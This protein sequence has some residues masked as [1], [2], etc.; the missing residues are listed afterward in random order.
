MTTTQMPDLKSSTV[1]GPPDLIRSPWAVARDLVIRNSML[2]IMLGA[3]VVFTMSNPRF[4]SLANLQTILIAAAPLA[5]IAFGQTLVILTA[6]IDL[7]VGSIISL[8]AMTASWM[9]MDGHTSMWVAVAAAIAVGLA[10]GAVNGILVAVLHVPPFVATLAT[11]TAGSG[12]AYV[13]G[14]GAPITGLPNSYGDLANARILGF[15]LPVWIAVF[16]FVVLVV[17]MR[18]TTYGTRIYA[19]GGNPVASQ[20]AGI[21][22]KSVLF[23]VYVASGALAGLSGMLLS[24]RVQSGFPYLGVGYELSSIAAVVIGGASLMGGRGTMWG[25]AIG[26]LLIQTMNNGLDILLI[27]SY[28]QQVIVGALIA[29]AVAV[30]AFVT[31]RLR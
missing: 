24:S 26:L 8:S 10:V 19:V 31:R 16:G 22:V 2:F 4:A 9:I 23:T 17:V 7:S 15:Q 30:D 21:K 25:T 27:P 28:W 29:S 6:G 5:L 11:L 14:S 13:V 3:T 1:Q 12:L 20:I 18:R